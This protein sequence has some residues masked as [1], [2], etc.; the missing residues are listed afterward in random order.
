MIGVTGPVVS[1]HLKKLTCSIATAA[2][3]AIAC[4]PLAH[5]Q[6]ADTIAGLASV[7]KNSPL[8]L[9]ADE[10][11]YDHDNA[12]VAAVGSVKI[13]YGGTK[14]VAHRVVY[15]QRSGR[16]LA[17][18]NVEIIQPDGTKVYADEIDITD[19]FADGFVNA[20]RIV[21]PDKT[22]FAAES[23]ERSNGD[24]TTFNNGV[25]TACEP[26][27]ENPDK[28][29]IWQIK[30]RKIIWNGQEKTVR[31]EDA[32]FEFFG[33]P[34]AYAPVFTT[35]DPTVKR[36]T[37]FL[38]PDVSYAQERGFG[39]TIPYFM[40]L[41]P[42]YDLTVQ[43]TGYTRQGF[44]A[45]AEF[46]QRLRNGTYSVRVAGIHQMSPG[47]F[48]SNTVDSR[49]VNRGMVGTQGTFTINPR[50]TFGWNVLAQTDRDFSRTYGIDGFDELVQQNQIY[51]TGLND[52]NYFDLRFMKFDVQDAVEASKRDAQQ[53]WVLPSFD[54]ERIAPDPVAG[55]Q[56][57]VTVNAR[58]ISRD[59]EN[60]VGGKLSDRYAM[61][62]I[63]GRSG[64]ITAESEWQRT[65]IAPGGLAVTPLLALRGD[66]D[67]IDSPQSGK[68]VSFD[69]NRSYYGGVATAGLELRWPVLFTASN[70]SH[71]IE[72]MAQ[73]FARAGRMHPGLTPNEDAQSLVFD[74]TTLFQRDKFS[75]FDRI[76]DDTR[77]NVG[78]R[79]TGSF[80]NGVTLH[81]LFGQSYH[82]AGDNP[83]A[84]PD[85][86]NVG[87]DSGLATDVSDF[88]AM[89]GTDYKATLATA[90]RA[91]F[92][93]RTFEPRRVETE[94]SLNTR[95]FSLS[96]TYGYSRP[97]SSSGVED[98]QVSG[99]AAI[100]F[101]DYWSAFGTALYDI[102]DKRL[103]ST[104]VGLAYDDECFGVLFTY[105]QNKSATDAIK[106]TF[107][108]RLSFRT[109]GDIGG[110]SKDLGVN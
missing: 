57:S 7:K 15:K 90:V 67:Y 6:S 68:G 46:R 10:L 72:P 61:R 21:T 104:G 73:I 36:K 28:A 81:G 45:E 66:A 59:T 25:Y 4:A 65:L 38:R 60:S 1:R 8:L 2:L 52:R 33:H 91:R 63:D 44:L 100:R 55:G 53:P 64:R 78:I 42:N 49:N 41:A 109:L 20:L 85:L 82:L 13:D 47:A 103:A 31:F 92:D 58:M 69:G 54:Y 71:V 43:G 12:E 27:R 62:G 56:L 95:P 77:A 11:I 88:V 19:D 22:Y 97:E 29:P 87:T 50:W 84:A 3:V 108:L 37:G 39:L 86:V 75:G 18:G 107:G 16:L 26:C 48:D 83:F 101:A 110:A 80:A 14:I 30:A 93:H 40:A 96:G 70:S 99:R 74:T 102:D 9:E 32:T 17:I 24:L 23:G 105:T 106:R 94:A 76:E 5:A 89:A 98:H 35:A 51:L 34:I 79:Y